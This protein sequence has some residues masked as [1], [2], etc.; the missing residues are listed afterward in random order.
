MWH[1]Y[2]ANPRWYPDLS[3]DLKPSLLVLLANR[4]HLGESAKA[5]WRLLAG[6]LIY[7]PSSISDEELRNGLQSLDK[8]ALASL[9]SSFVHIVH[10]AEPSGRRETWERG[11]RRA[12]GLWPLDKQLRSESLSGTL[13]MLATLLEAD[14]EAVAAA[15]RARTSANGSSTA[16]FDNRPARQAALSRPPIVHASITGADC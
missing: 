15:I 13:G 10:Q 14:F 7:S 8:D 16:V 12:L 5:L 6:V 4:N 3:A 2:L 9:A 11:I 1:G